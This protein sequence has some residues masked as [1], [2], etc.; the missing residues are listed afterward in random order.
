MPNRAASPW[1]GITPLAVLLAAVL[2][3]LGSTAMLAF[4]AAHAAWGFV[5]WWSAMTLLGLGFVVLLSGIVV[6]HEYDRRFTAD[7]PLAAASDGRPDERN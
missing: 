2:L 7:Q 1:W 3:N 6:A 4:S 5:V